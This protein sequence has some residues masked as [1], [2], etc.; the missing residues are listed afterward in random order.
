MARALSLSEVRSMASVHLSREVG[1]D[2]SS[3]N[4]HTSQSSGLFLCPVLAPTPFCWPR[5]QLAWR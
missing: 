1:G 2:V 3:Q 5:Q 4:R